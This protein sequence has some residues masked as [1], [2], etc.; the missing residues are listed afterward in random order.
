VSCGSSSEYTFS[1]RTRRAIS[2]ANWLPKSSTMTVS[3]S[4]A[5]P[6]R[7]GGGAWSACSR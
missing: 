1:S 5:S 3:G 2:W 7:S 6:A 4:A